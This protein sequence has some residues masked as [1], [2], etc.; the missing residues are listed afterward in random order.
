MTIITCSSRVVRRSAFPRTGLIVGLLLI[1]MLLG[2]CTEKTWRPANE[3]VWTE[4][5]LNGLRGK[6]RDDIREFLGAPTGLYTIDAKGRWHYPHMKVED[7][8][9]RTQYEATVKIY[10]SQLGEQR[11]TIIEITKQTE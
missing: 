6:S 8:E 4:A 3:R 2:A 10:F 1:G 7:P 11:A 9:T 5:E